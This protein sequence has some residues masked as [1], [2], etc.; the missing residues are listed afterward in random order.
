MPSQAS[1][2]NK[3]VKRYWRMMTH[4]HQ[5]LIRCG[6]TAYKASLPLLPGRGL[7][8]RQHWGKLTLD[9]WPLV[10]C[11]YLLLRRHHFGSLETLVTKVHESHS[12]KLIFIPSSL[13]RVSMEG[14]QGWFAIR[15]SVVR[16]PVLPW[17]GGRCG[18]TQQPFTAAQRRAT[19]QLQC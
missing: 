10:L 12:L 3:G 1:S 11:P 9:L 8:G 18:D 7:H 4:H 2:R 13:G 5:W 19:N 6:C 16:V 14:T 15:S 17:A